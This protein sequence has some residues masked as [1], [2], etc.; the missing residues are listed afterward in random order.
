MKKILESAI[1]SSWYQQD[2]DRQDRI[3]ATSELEK[4]HTIL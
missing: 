1:A 4:L 2:A 3:M